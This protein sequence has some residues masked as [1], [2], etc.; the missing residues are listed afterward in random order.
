MLI[1]ALLSRSCS[2]PQRSQRQWRSA[3]FRPAWIAPHVEQVLLDG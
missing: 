2:L 3:S 1:A